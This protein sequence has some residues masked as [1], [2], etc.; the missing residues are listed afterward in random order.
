MSVKRLV[1]LAS[2]KIYKHVLNVF[3]KHIVSAVKIYQL[4]NTIIESG[5]YICL[6]KVSEKV[7][8]TCKFPICA[9]NSVKLLKIFLCHCLL[10]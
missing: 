3:K 10:R 6:L 7:S 2:F 5:S 4:L 9:Q 1:V 8:E